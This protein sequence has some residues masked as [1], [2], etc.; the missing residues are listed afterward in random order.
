[1]KQVLLDRPDCL[2]KD[3]STLVGALLLAALVHDVNHPGCMNGLLIATKHPLAASDTQAVLE[4]HHA[5][6]ALALLD[7]PQL[8]FLSHL[9]KDHRERVIGLVRDVV[10]ATDVTT[11]M[12][13]AKQVTALV[14]GNEQPMPEQV[15]R[16]IVK[17]ADIS[18][19]ARS[20]HVYE[21]W[22]DGVLQE[23]FAQG[24]LE[25]ERGLP[26][27]MNCDR[28]TVTLPKSQVG[29]ITFLVGPLFNALLAVAPSLQPMVDSLE[30]NRKHF[31]EAAAN[32]AAPVHSRP[33]PS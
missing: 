32:A 25:R 10:L 26:I 7:R 20:L 18:N 3:S 29:F 19:P 12:P 8:N 28:E 30:S 4:R 16:L 5:E 21:R 13:L 11:T 17:A 15:M 23:F 33:Q 14:S 1:M 24:D 31:E 22:I 2:G 27:S 9:S 6:V